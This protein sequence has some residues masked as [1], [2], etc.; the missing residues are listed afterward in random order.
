[1][2]VGGIV[3]DADARR[4]RELGVARVFTPKDFGITDIMAEVVA[5]VREANGLDGPGAGLTQ[6]DDDPLGG[7]AAGGVEHGQRG[8]GVRGSTGSGPR[9]RTAA[10]NA[11]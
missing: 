5:V 9:P 4:L 8:D 6:R 2:V 11:G 10:A 7:A 3:P 1:M